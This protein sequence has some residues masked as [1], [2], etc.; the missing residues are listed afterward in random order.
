MAYR[1]LDSEK[2]KTG[3]VI[4]ETSDG[5]I[6]AL[7]KAGDR[8]K[9]IDERVPAR[10]SHAFIYVG[11]GYIM[12]ADEGVRSIL[13]A[14]IIT[15]KPENFLVLRHPE[16][17]NG[18]SVE[19]LGEFSSM[20]VFAAIHPEVNK[21]YNWRG[22]FGTK[23]LFVGSRE[24]TF[25]CSQ[26]VG[27]AYRRL[28]IDLLEDGRPPEL[29]TPNSLL[30]KQ[31]KLEPIDTEACFTQLP[32]ADWVSAI[33]KVNRYKVIENEPIP[34]AQISHDLSKKMVA[35]FGRRIDAATT[36]IGK[37]QTIRSPQDII[38]TLYFPDLPDGD[39]IAD[40]IV[41]FMKLNYPSDQIRQ[42]RKMCM[43]AG[44]ELLKIGDRQLISMMKA[45]L[46]RD[47]HSVQPTLAMTKSEIEMMTAI[48][49]PPYARRS[50]HRWRLA[51]LRE[52]FEEETDFLEWRESFLARIG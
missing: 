23:L 13:A 51:K 8:I 6:S 2:L 12:E 25:F 27:E 7:I 29:V 41:S 5:K 21:D 46:I 22:V 16:H 15:D 9:E 14:R 24:G 17:P 52:S 18:I 48:P 20:G 33:A 39:S 1:F 34:L 49:S 44:E 11:M 30:S 50:F 35:T 36:M 31:C 38:A 26:L 40:D 10:F 45:T 42:Y 3:D 19:W 47:I 32:G 43:I 4:L 28:K 37:T